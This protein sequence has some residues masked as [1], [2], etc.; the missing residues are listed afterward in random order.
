[1]PTRPS[2]LE[3]LL[4]L[5]FPDHCVSCRRHGTL[6]CKQCCN[7]LELYTEQL[8]ILPGL[9]GVSI[10]Y[11]YRDT[12][13]TAIHQLKYRRRRRV[14]KPLGELLTPLAQPHSASIDA[15]Q[16]IPMHAARRAERGFNQAELIAQSL[17]ATLGKP[18]LVRGLERVRA[19]GQQVRLNAHERRE[20]MRDAFAWQAT[21]PPP[22]RILLVDDVLT[23]GATMSA[24]AVALR[25]AG[26]REVYGIAL[27]RSRLK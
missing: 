25:E 22:A 11:V 6:L 27:A 24:C 12:L 26:C 15:L 20:N 3:S 1:M 9:D 8:H 16:P 17:G 18:C 2:L 4:T 21:A 23:T 14:A 19:T 10:A 13:R 7:G 5:L